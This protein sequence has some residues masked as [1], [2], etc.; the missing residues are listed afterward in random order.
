MPPPNGSLTANPVLLIV[1]TFQKVIY[2]PAPGVALIDHTQ[3]WY[4]GH[5]SIWLVLSVAMLY[6]ALRI[7]SRLEDNFAEEI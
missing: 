2:N 5:L 1:I 4:L 6:G 7:F 3:L